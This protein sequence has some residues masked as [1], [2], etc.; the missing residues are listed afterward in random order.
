M[1]EFRVAVAQLDAVAGSPQRNLGRIEALLRQL[2]RKVDLVVFPELYLT[3]YGLGPRLTELAEPPDGAM[4]GRLA[5][6][7]RRHETA[8]IVGFPERAGSSIYNSAAV[9]DE[10]GHLAG[11][12]RKIHLF[13]Q[14]RETFAAGQEPVVVQL[15]SVRVGICICYDLEFP[16]TARMLALKGAELI[17]VSTANM[18]P[19]EEQQDVYCRARAMENQVFL[20]VANRVGT[21]GPIEFF[22]RSAIVGPMGELL[23]RAPDGREAVVDAVLQPADVDEARKGPVS[24]LRDRRPERYGLLVQSEKAGNPDRPGFSGL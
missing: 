14:E 21:E 19:W 10:R 20:A 16:E 15:K 17:A 23:V 4:V 9:I 5:D 11:V 7:A 18:R 24:Y 2:E 1:P 13:D 8:L 12:H 22:G 3:G 6:L